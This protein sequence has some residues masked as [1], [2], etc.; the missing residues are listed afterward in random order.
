MLVAV[1]RHDRQAV[2]RQVGCI[3]RA[4]NRDDS[5]FSSD[6][7]DAAVVAADNVVGDGAGAWVRIGG[8]DLV[9]GGDGWLVWGDT[10]STLMGARQPWAAE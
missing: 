9:V 6:A 10:S 3:F 2:L 8:Q 7:E 1:S 4:R 5:G